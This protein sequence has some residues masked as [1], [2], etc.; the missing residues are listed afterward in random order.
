MTDHARISA[1]LDAQAAE[2]CAST[3]TRLAYGRDL[4]DFAGWLGRR[5][6]GFDII[7]LRRAVAAVD[8]EQGDGERALDAIVAAGGGIE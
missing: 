6:L 7:V 1:F 8:R 3:N 4:K 2:L 5:G